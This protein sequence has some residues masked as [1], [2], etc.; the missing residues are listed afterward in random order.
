MT[1][2]WMTEAG[3]RHHTTPDCFALKAGQEGGRAQGYD[4]R[5]IVEVDLNEART[6]GKTA[7]GTCDSASTPRT[8]NGD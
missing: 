4:L 6:A 2:V 3:D 5:D 8:P 1:R 7:C